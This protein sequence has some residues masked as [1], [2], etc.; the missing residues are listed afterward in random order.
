MR[1]AAAAALFAGAVTAAS[2]PAYAQTGNLLRCVVHH[3]PEAGRLATCTAPVATGKGEWTFQIIGREPNIVTRVEIY[4]IG[5]DTP[6]Q[7]LEGFELRPT[8]VRGDAR[9]PGRIDIVLQDVDF[10]RHADLR[11]AIGPAGA[12]G[13]AYRWFLFDRGADAFAPTGLLDAIRSPIVNARRK[14]IQGVFTDERGRTG[15][16]VLKWRD[17]KLEPLSAIARERTEDGRC[18]ASHYV[19]REGKFEKTRET[20]CRPGAEPGED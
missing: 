17:G 7:V 3:S 14:S 19:R 12:E 18:I 4:E 2:P 13:T 15:R 8:L 20:E 5:R 10:D 16:M 9:T 1:L 6:R 11:I